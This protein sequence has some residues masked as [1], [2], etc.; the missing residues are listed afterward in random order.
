MGITRMRNLAAH[1]DDKVND[2]LLWRALTARAPSPL[3][4]LDLELHPS[5]GSERQV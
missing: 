5:S 4:G 3:T 2:H 1:L